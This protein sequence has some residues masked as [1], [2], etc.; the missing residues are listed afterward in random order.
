M[1]DERIIE[2]KNS[3]LGWSIFFLF[4]TV[5]GGILGLIYYFSINGSMNKVSRVIKNISHDTKYL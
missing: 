5:I 4:F 2:E 3:I 1:T